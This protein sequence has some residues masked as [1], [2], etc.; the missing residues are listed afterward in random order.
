M[1]CYQAMMLFRPISVLDTI[2][3]AIGCHVHHGMP[4]HDLA[5]PLHEKA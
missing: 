4:T 5:P 3:S 2:V 1:T